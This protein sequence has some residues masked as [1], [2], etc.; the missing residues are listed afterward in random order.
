MTADQSS[1]GAMSGGAADPPMAHA[2]PVPCMSEQ[3]RMVVG[4]NSAS[5]VTYARR[6]VELLAIEGVRVHLLVSPLGQ[7][8]LHE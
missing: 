3:R 8:L 5:G 7:R 6:C 1:G 4:I 2:T